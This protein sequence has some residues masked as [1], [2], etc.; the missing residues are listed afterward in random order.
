[1]GHYDNAGD[2]RGKDLNSNLCVTVIKMIWINGATFESLSEKYDI[3]L[4]INAE[5]PEVYKA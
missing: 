2:N 5:E 3:I 1:M 4:K